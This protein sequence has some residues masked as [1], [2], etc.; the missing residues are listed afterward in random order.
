MGGTR[1]RVA[2]SRP[3]SPE[4][5]QEL[6]SSVDGLDKPLQAQDKLR[7]QRT[8]VLEQFQLSIDRLTGENVSL[9][10]HCEVLESKLQQQQRES[11]RTQERH[12][13][14]LKSLEQS[15]ATKLVDL[16]AEM[17]QALAAETEARAFDCCFKRMHTVT[18]AH[19]L[20]VQVNRRK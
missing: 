3:N 12:D 2:Q 19:T 6:I 9:V 8:E 16:K 7:V 1:T 5:L 15:F 13:R 14:S 11:T 18:G 20:V 4:A 10:H 17:L